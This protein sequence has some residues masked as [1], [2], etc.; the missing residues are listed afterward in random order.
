MD[1]QIDTNISTSAHRRLSHVKVVARLLEHELAAGKGS[2]DVSLE[3]DLL[4]NVLDTLEMYVE[5][6]EEMHAGG[7][8]AAARPAVD[9]KP[10]VTR[11]N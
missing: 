8:P 2:K 6:F 4:E 9:A 5:D 10:A 3:R 7:K 1:K 11:L